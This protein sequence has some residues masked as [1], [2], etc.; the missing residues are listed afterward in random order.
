VSTACRV[1]KAAEK[2]KGQPCTPGSYPGDCASHLCDPVTKTCLQTCQP[3]L[4]DCRI[5]TEVCNTFPLP[6][7]GAQGPAMACTKPDPA[8]TKGSDCTNSTVCSAK[9][10]QQNVTFTCSR[11]N[12]TQTKKVGDA[13]NANIKFPGE[14]QTHLCHPVLKVCVNTCTQ[15]SDCTDASRPKCGKILLSGGQLANACIPSQSPCDYDGTCPASEPICALEIVN[16][17]LVKRCSTGGPGTKKTGES[18]DPSKKIP[19]DCANR[20]C[21]EGT[22]K[23]VATCNEDAHCPQGLKCISTPVE[24]NRSA[25]ACI[26]P[27]GSTCEYERD[28]SKPT[29]CQAVRETTGIVGK[30]LTPLGLDNGLKCTPK[31]LSSGNYGF[32]TGCKSQ[33][34][35]PDSKRCTTICRTNADCP[36]GHCETMMLEGFPTKVCNAACEISSDCHTGEICGPVAVPGNNIERLCRTPDAQ[37]KPLGAACDP[38]KILYA[39]CQSG[40][41]SPV[42]SKC[43]TFCKQDTDCG[44]G[45]ICDTSFVRVTAG[46]TVTVQACVPSTGGCT[47][48]SQCFNDY[49]CAPGNRNGSAILLC[50]KRSQSALAT[51]G[52]C[53]PAAPYPQ[54]CVSRLCDPQSKQC[55]EP[56]RS[57]ADCTQTPRTKCGTISILGASF[58]AC[59][60]KP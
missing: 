36:V 16:N 55:T 7:T 54:D 44:T 53:N 43:T 45:E 22:L 6:V 32:V 50:L 19:G 8:C 1:P 5:G 11:I 42:T 60:A 56:C 17:A 12:N 41:C 14:C 25:K 4:L 47:H 35:H 57:D 37:L 49:Y 20:F 21:E 9:V 13:C 52:A 48:N 34:C 31:E 33:I 29:I 3:G 15:D 39:E 26:R 28:C 58:P 51:G 23:C 2:T 24:G 38:S 46:A 40:F 30:C 59:T 27:A 10:D 18:C